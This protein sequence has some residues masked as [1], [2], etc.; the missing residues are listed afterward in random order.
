M[1]TVNLQA[2]HMTLALMVVMAISA[3]CWQALEEGY[4]R[5]RRRKP[6]L[7]TGPRAYSADGAPSAAQWLLA[8][9]K[10]G[11]GLGYSDQRHLMF[12]PGRLYQP[13]G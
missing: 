4:P 10:Q 9:A 6:F 3:L 11:Q 13:L 7:L 12:H 1:L 5:R 8:N 2:E